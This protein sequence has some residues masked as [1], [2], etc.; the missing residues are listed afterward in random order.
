M[1]LRLGL[2]GFG[3]VAFHFCQGMIA[4]GATMGDVVA[5]YHRLGQQ[6]ES[7]RR[8]ADL[9]V[10]LTNDPAEFGRRCDVVLSVAVP[11][12]AEGA[13]RRVVPHLQRQIFADLN[14]TSPGV[15]RSLSDLAAAHGVPFADVAIL[16]SV[17]RWQQRVPMVASG[18]AAAALAVMLAPFGTQIRLLGAEVGAA[19]RFK[20]IRSAY[21]KGTALLMVE[22]LVAADRAGLLAAMVEELSAT[23]L[24]SPLPQRLEAEIKG[25]IK[26]ARRQTK[27]LAYVID[28]FEE[29]GLA[30][31]VMP[32][33]AQLLADIG[34]R[35]EPDPAR[36][37]QED[38]GRLGSVLEAASGP[39]DS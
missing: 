28:T 20:M 4:S 37:W 12:G 10:R 6:T 9:G 31:R 26:H 7:E 30:C 32:A 3:E 11:H 2:V 34:G 35:T 33:I 25:T 27:E 5:Y 8:A 16:G 19:A 36:T 14:S 23:E 13:A 39:L 38:V 29:L 17:A 22:T 15:K 21:T 1:P 18:P 24:A